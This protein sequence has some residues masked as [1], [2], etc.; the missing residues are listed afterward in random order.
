MMN[1]VA[2]KKDRTNRQAA[3]A[4]T[5]IAVCIFLLHAQTSFTQSNAVQHPWQKMQMPTAAEVERTWNASPPEYGHEPYYGLNGA[6]TRE[7]LQRDLAKAVRLGFHAVT[8]Q[9]G[10]NPGIPGGSMP[11]AGVNTFRNIKLANFCLSIAIENAFRM[12]RSSNGALLR[13][14]PR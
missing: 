2:I 5:T 13:S 4:W 10:R 3:M 11:P 12:E 7:V 8:V 1:P 9:P 14:K 6:V